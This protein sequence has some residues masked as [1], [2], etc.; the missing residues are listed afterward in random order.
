M[1]AVISR[2]ITTRLKMERITPKLTEAQKWNDKNGIHPKEGK[3][4]HTRQNK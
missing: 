3:K 2:A 1:L 4:Q